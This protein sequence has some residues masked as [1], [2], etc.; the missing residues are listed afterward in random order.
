[1]G[2]Y[3]GDVALKMT[4]SRRRLKYKKGISMRA[5]LA[6]IQ[7]HLLYGVRIRSHGVVIVRHILNTIKS[8][9]CSSANDFKN[10]WNI[11]RVLENQIRRSA[12]QGGEII[13]FRILEF[14]FKFNL[15]CKTTSSSN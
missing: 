10:I 15:E 4:L 3:S 12:H 14:D 11:K 13:Q 5:S 6:W 7:S 2:G 8:F 9:L 1:M